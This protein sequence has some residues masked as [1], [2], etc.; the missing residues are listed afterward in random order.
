M[1]KLQGNRNRTCCLKRQV[2]APCTLGLFITDSYIVAKGY[3][4]SASLRMLSSLRRL[5]QRDGSA[6]LAVGVGEYMYIVSETT[7]M[8]HL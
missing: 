4:L 1:R 2:R 8:P 5:A 6:W 3:T 7:I